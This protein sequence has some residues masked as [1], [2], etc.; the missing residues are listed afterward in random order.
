MSRL[1]ADNK[2]C[3]TVLWLN[4]WPMELWEALRP[5][6]NNRL[7]NGLTDSEE[8]WMCKWTDKFRDSLFSSIKIKWVKLWVSCQKWFWSP[9]TNK[10]RSNHLNQPFIKTPQAWTRSRPLCK[11]CITL[12]LE[13]ITWASQAVVSGRT[14]TQSTLNKLNSSTTSFMLEKILLFQVLVKSTPNSLMS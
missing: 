4:L 11:T 13:T 3:K 5:T 6:Q 12:P 14:L 1:E 9:H 7:R 8:C 2:D 10:S